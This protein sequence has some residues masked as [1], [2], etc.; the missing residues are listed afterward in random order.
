MPVDH[1][2]L[3]HALSALRRQGA[4]DFADVLQ[5]VLSGLRP[6]LEGMADSR[7]TPAGDGAG[8]ARTFSE[9][10]LT[11]TDVINEVYLN[12]AGNYSVA[13]YNTRLK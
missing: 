12:A 5:N 6:Q 8:V 3:M 11:T 4:Q 13:G 10:T 7:E 9:I 2:R 1:A